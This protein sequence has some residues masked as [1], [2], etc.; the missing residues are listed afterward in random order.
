MPHCSVYSCICISTNKV[1][2]VTAV[3]Y[4]YIYIHILYLWDY[5]S[6]QGGIFCEKSYRV[7]VRHGLK[8]LQISALT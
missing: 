6:Y 5:V 4:L 1:K 3:I 8:E 2:I 7:S